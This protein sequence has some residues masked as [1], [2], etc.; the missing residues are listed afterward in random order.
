MIC[1]EK[2]YTVNPFKHLLQAPALLGYVY[3]ICPL[4]HLVLHQVAVGK[5]P[6]GA[7]AAARGVSHRLVEAVV[8]CG[9]Q[10]LTC[11]PGSKGYSQ[12]VQEQVLLAYCSKHSNLQPACE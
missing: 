2:L 5:T 9:E 12:G 4:R 1:V 6:G 11:C 8:P 10:I 3:G 7:P